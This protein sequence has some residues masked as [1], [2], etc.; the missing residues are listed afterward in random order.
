[1][2]VVHQI[3]G[4]KEIVFNLGKQIRG[5]E[6]KLARAL[7]KAGLFIQRESQKRVPVEFGVLKAS[8][9]TRA[10][11]LGNRTDVVV[12]YTAPY[13]LWVHEKVLMK[14]KGQP[15]RPSP[16]HKGRYWDPQG[17]AEARFLENVVNQKQQDIIQI[18]IAEMKNP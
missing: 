5:N 4:V 3:Q 16:P 13:A 18:I 17:K 12:G 15:R 6:Q 11:Q 2:I 7:K 1:V 10:F 14:L 8:A 9:F